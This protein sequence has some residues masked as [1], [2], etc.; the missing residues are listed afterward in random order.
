MEGL[1]GG[2]GDETRWTSTDRVLAESLS[3]SCMVEMVVVGKQ[4]EGDNSE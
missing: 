1:R 3:E 4:E 2:G